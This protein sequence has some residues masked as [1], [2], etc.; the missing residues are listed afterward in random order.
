MLTVVRAIHSLLVV[1]VDGGRSDGR[2]AC[3]AEGPG[4]VLHIDTQVSVRVNLGNHPSL[5]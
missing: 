2:D 4:L 1:I 5:S 3:R